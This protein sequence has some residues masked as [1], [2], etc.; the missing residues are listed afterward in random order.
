[1]QG[2]KIVRFKKIYKSA[3]SAFIRVI[4]FH[5]F[6]KNVFI[7]TKNSIFLSKYTRYGKNVKKQN[8]LFQEKL[9]LWSQTFFIGVLSFVY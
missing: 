2:K 9:Q 4:H 7:R 6:I 8:C 5:L 3:S 1:M